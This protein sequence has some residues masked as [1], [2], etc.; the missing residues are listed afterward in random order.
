MK[1]KTGTAY[2]FC[3]SHILNPAKIKI[4]G[5]TS[6]DIFIAADSG[7]ETAE[8]L[9]ITPDVLIGDFDSIDFSPDYIADIKII[10][11][12]AEKN[13]TD[14][15]L[16]VKYAIGLGYKN[17]AVIG[18]IDGRTDH[19][20]ANLFYLKHIKKQGGFG[21]ITNGYNKISYLADSKT[22]IGKD[23]KY[24]S[25]VPVSPEICVT[26]KGF[27]YNLENAAV[28]FEEPYTVSNEIT[29]DHGEIGIISGEALICE[30]DDS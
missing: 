10:K 19:T 20:L 1:M 17:I 4:P 29:E 27:K 8:K 14:S 24:I 6:G 11:H 5:N 3:K 16:A 7:I 22:I 12:P 9:N 25:V 23:Y 21:Y 26:L 2:I 15:M 18:G 30:C 13:D 28:R